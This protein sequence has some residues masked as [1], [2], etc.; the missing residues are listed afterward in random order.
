[1]NISRGFFNCYKCV[2]HDFFRRLNHLLPL[3]VPCIYSSLGKVA[4][5]SRVSSFLV[6]GVL[7]QHLC[8]PLDLCMTELCRKGIWWWSCPA[9]QSLLQMDSDSASALKG[10]HMSVMGQSL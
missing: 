7:L 1:M 9:G 6:S 5:C 2:F 4:L 8:D 3:Q 10:R